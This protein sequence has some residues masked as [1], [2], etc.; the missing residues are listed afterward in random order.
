MREDYGKVIIIGPERLV[1]QFLKWIEK[2]YPSQDFSSAEDPYEVIRKKI[3]STPEFI[4]G[5]TVMYEG[6]TVWSK[7]RLKEEIERIAREH[8]GRLAKD[9]E[10]YMSNYFYDFCVL[11]CTTAH[12]D[13]Y[14]WL[15]YYSHLWDVHRLLEEQISQSYIDRRD[16]KL[17]TYLKNKIEREVKDV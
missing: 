9:D 5:L 7:K 3:D 12:Y 11:K 13:K 14:G 8:E 1:E 6:S 10:V 2:K 16:K 4:Y 15:A 17:F